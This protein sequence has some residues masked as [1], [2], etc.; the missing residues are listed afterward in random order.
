VEGRQERF[1]S[2]AEYEIRVAGAELGGFLLIVTHAADPEQ[3]TPD[4]FMQALG[5]PVTLIGWAQTDP[6]R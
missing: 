4:R 1:S 3:M 6:T 5:S 2:E